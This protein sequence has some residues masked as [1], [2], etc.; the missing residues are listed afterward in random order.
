MGG[1][2]TDSGAVAVQRRE[3]DL[4]I[5][6]KSPTAQSQPQPQSQ[7]RV[8]GFHPAS[9]VE[10]APTSPRLSADVMWVRTT[11]GGVFLRVGGLAAPSPSSESPVGAGCQVAEAN[12]EELE[13]LAATASA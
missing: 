1:P 10:V 3:V 9:T 7:C 2:R 13:E 4:H 11:L 6:A 5:P 8:R 12:A